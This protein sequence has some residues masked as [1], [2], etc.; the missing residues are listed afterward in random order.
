MCVCVCVCVCV[1]FTNRFAFPTAWQVFSDA[2]FSDEE[3]DFLL[4]TT[5]YLQATAT[6]NDYDIDLVDLNYALA[7][8]ANDPSASPVAL[9]A[10]VVD[11]QVSGASAYV[12][13]S[14]LLTAG[15][16][17]QLSQVCALDC[18]L[19]CRGMLRPVVRPERTTMETID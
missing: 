14:V 11:N 6:S 17:P 18:G 1:C 8:P 5:A 4:G 2:A 15:G 16:F 13:F 3:D 7:T 9:P 19:T 10:V 12:R